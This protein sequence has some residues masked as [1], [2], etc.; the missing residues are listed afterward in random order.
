[1]NS[2]MLPGRR[3]VG[4]RS[5]E[6]TDH[7]G[8]V[9]TVVT[10]RKFKIGMV[11]QPAYNNPRVRSYNDFYPFGF[12][13][14]NRTDALVPYR[15]GFGGQ[16]KDNEIYGEG[17]SYTAEFW[18]YDARLGRRWNVEPLAREFPWLSPYAVFLNNPIRFSDVNG[19]GPGDRIRA[20]RA[21]VGKSYLK[22]TG[23]LRT[24]EDAPAL[25][26]MDCS[27]LVSRVLA[28]DGITKGIVSRST[29]ELMNFLNNPEMFDKSMSD[30]RPGDIVLWRGDGGGHTGIVSEVDDNGRIK[31][32]HAAGV[33]YGVVED[34]NFKQVKDRDGQPFQG[35]F[36]PREES[37]IQLDP[38]EVIDQKPDSKIEL[39]SPNY[40]FKPDFKLPN[41]DLTP[42]Q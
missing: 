35:F 24:G 13:M 28:A 2:V 36:R 17:A 37:Y 33:D 41:I 1:M 5:Y 40:D 4:L 6:L 3:D 15:Y 9:H 21:F 31:M 27:E 29:A 23:K 22:E 25:E 7:L 38:V 42:Q 11:G 16:E 20:A 12:P 10:D 26:K 32:I 39:K 14:P 30:P 19:K 18:Q 8:N 34:K